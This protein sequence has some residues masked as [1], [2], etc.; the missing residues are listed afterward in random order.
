VEAECL[1]AYCINL[2][3]VMILASLVGTLRPRF[4]QL[5]APFV[6]ERSDLAFVQL[7]S[8]VR[9]YCYRGDSCWT[10]TFRH[11]PSAKY[12]AHRRAQE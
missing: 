10:G 2:L 9:S 5:S 6:K 11:S 4:N 1:D 12:E 3:G 7:V 8:L